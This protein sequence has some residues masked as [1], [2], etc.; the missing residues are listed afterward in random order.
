[1]RVLSKP[2]FEQG[3]KYNELEI[4]MDNFGVLK[5][6]IEEIYFETIDSN[7]NKKSDRS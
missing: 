5:S 2:E 1:M 3:V 4:L 6:S 7:T